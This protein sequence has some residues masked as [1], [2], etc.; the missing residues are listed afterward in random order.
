MRAC[1]TDANHA[2]IVGC[3]R[4]Y[5]VVVRDLSRVGEGCPDLLCGARGRWVLLE[6]KNPEQ[7]KSKQ[8]LRKGQEEFRLLATQRGLPVFV[9]T[10]LREA[11]VA[12]EMVAQ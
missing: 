1:R 9:V 8:R 2:A 10:T 4:K 5:G 6:V 12:L 11:L 7:P 3:L